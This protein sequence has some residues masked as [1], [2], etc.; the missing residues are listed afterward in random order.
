MI[1]DDKVIYLDKGFIVEMYEKV[2]G[3]DA[4]SKYMKTTD[5]SLGISAIAKAG[6]SLKETFEYPISSSSMYKKLDSNLSEIQEIDLQESD[7]RDLPDYFWMEGLFG[8]ISMKSNQESIRRFNFS[9]A[10]E[11]GE[12]QLFLAT[13]DVYFSSGYDQ[14]LGFAPSF[15]DNYVVK[16]KML[17]KSL[18]TTRN[19][20]IAAPMVIIKQ[21]NFH[22]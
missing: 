12:K 14:L 1:L 5:V 9:A 21:G 16:A 18:G 13:N 17:L 11:K 15:A 6:A 20:S 19:F 22:K 4:P 10:A 2:Y 3:K 7:I 8:I